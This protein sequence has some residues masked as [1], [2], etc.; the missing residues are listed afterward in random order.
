MGVDRRSFIKMSGA[1]VAAA[2]TVRGAEKQ[3]P[4]WRAGSRINPAVDNLRVVCCH[5]PSMVTSSCEEMPGFAKMEVQ[6]GAVSVER[7]QKNLDAMALALTQKS[8]PADA[9]AV[10]LRKPRDKPWDKVRAAI[11][12]N[13]IADNHPRLAVVD[14]ICRELNALG[15]SMENIVIYDGCHNAHQ[16]YAAYVGKGLPEGVQ[17][18]EKSSLL[19][20]TTEAQTPSPDNGAYDCSADV[21][22]GAI[23]ILVNCAVNKGH[24]QKFG[25]ATL[26]MKN[27]FGTFTPQPHGHGDLDY[28]LAINKSDAIVGG[29][30]A[31]QQLCIVDSLWAS[32]HGPRG[33]PNK[34]THRLVMGVFGPAVDYLTI[35]KIREPIMGAEHN[36]EALRRFATEFGYEPAAFEKAEL[37]EV[38]PA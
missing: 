28:V 21:A 2:A 8:S 15:V 17:V 6:N 5:D 38:K 33:I 26:T 11:K 12:V 22:T 19:G 31:R 32:T 18:S 3:S 24:G 34:D 27:H 23:D 13:S 35:K 14:K 1:A 7:V 16:H 4:G 30:P 10:L 20:G 9:W 25:G 36:E 29:E 37:V